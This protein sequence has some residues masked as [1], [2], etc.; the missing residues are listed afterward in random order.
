MQETQKEGR[1]LRRH[2]KQGLGGIE[3]GK[4]FKKIQE[5]RTCWRHR[6]K[7]VLAGNTLRKYFA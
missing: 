7:K 3:R 2:R 6:K 4:D 1:T 5:A